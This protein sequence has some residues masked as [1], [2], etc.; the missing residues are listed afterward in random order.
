[1]Y[2]EINP[3]LTYNANF[4]LVNGV[5]SIGK[6]YGTLKYMIK[7]CIEIKQEFVYLCRTQIEKKNGVLEKAL[8]KVIT[9]EFG[10]YEITFDKENGYI[11]GEVFCYCFA[12]TEMKALK[13]RSFQNVKYIFF[14]EY[15]L[16]NNIGYINGW[17][18]PDL[19]LNIYHTIDRDTDKVICFMMGN[20]TNFYNPYHIHNAF[21]IP[22]VA[23]GEIYHNGNVVFYNADIS[24]ELAEKKNSSKF[25]QMIANSDYGSYANAGE[26]SD[27]NETDFISKLHN[28]NM[29]ICTI[30]I[31]GQNFGMY[32]D[33]ITNYIIISDK[34][35]EH[36]AKRYA[37]NIKDMTAD[38][39]LL[40]KQDYVAKF[41]AKNM[42]F[43][44]LKFVSMETKIK[45]YPT[46]YKLL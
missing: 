45:T 7:K 42:K 26:Y 17:H 18:E 16:E 29:Y 22:R 25:S 36:C 13:R 5:R 27:Q 9:N 4:I 8:D 19:L 23:K 35:Q 14:D 3:L 10:K 40:I 2:F 1:M 34:W 20:N 43:S 41:I 38:T 28:K 24:Q 21:N 11:N 37:I 15:T 30:R 44:S 12:L 6:S 33:H 46:L 32:H 31:D 39:V